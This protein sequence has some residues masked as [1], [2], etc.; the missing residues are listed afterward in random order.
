MTEEGARAE[1]AHRHAPPGTGAFFREQRRIMGDGL[2]L[3][4]QTVA[5]RC[6]I[7]APDYG[8]LTPIDWIVLDF[9]D[10][11][12]TFSQMRDIVPATDESL[13]EAFVR[14]RLLGFL[15]WKT[16]PSGGARNA[17]P[18]SERHDPDS[19]VRSPSASGAADPTAMP[20]FDFGDDICAQYIPARLFAEFRRFSPKLFDSK[21]DLSNEM[22]AFVEF[23]YDN[24][25]TLSPCE[26][27]GIPPGTADKG[28]LRQAYMQRTKQFHPDR[29]FRKN[30]GPFAPRIAAIFKAVSNAFAKLQAS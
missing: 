11:M 12:R 19:A 26:I 22:Q 4:P 16:I 9:S 6:A 14:L 15:T 8:E 13:T 30:L 25:N 2:Y 24:L 21:L 18:R 28:A 10:G 5:R 27:L 29:Y 17:S 20:K 23:I 3:D 1:L 7:D